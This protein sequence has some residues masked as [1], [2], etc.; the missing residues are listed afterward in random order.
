M[1]NVAS[2]RTD[3]YLS[4]V[5]TH[6]SAGFKEGTVMLCKY[7]KGGG[8]SA[9]I[10]VTVINPRIHATDEYKPIYMSGTLVIAQTFFLD[11]SGNYRIPMAMG[12]GERVIKATVTFTGGSDQTMVIDFS[13]D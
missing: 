1:A 7:A 4:D 12:L 3:P 9:L 5:I 13:D 11:T 6:R 10:T 8:T 2:S